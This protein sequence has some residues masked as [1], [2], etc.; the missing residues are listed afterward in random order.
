[1]GAFSLIVVINLLNS[2]SMNTCRKISLRSVQQSNSSWALGF[3][4]NKKLYST[5]SKE[6]SG[7]KISNFK[8][9]TAVNSNYLPQKVEFN[10]ILPSKPEEPRLVK[11]FPEKEKL[12]HC[13][14]LLQFFEPKKFWGEELVSSCYGGNSWTCNVLRNKSNDELH[15]LWYVLLKE[16]NLL[17][18]LDRECEENE[19]MTPNDDRIDKVEESLENILK[20]V[21][22]RDSAYKLLEHDRSRPEGAY[23]WN[24]FGFRYWK[25]FREHAVPWWENERFRIERTTYRDYVIPWMRLRLERRR[26]RLLAQRLDFQKRLRESAKKYPHVPIPPLPRQFDHP[27]KKAKFDLNEYMQTQRSLMEKNKNSE[28]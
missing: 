3:L 11:H 26:Q 7:I 6:S 9:E 13:D 10:K 14:A 25:R 8:Q 17:S 19:K 22:E 23:A 4:T 16:R 20:I 1:M 12:K 27:M 21:E 24:I 15:K 2:S 5:R 18:T 28:N